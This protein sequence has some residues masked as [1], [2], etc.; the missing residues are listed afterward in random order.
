MSYNEV[1]MATIDIKQDIQEALEPLHKKIDLLQAGI[2]RQEYLTITEL[3]DYIKMSTAVIRERLAKREIPG[4]S[5][6]TGKWIFKKS[7]IDRWIEK[8]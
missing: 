5:K 2:I 3:S 1:L 6:V 4:A 7:I 8:G